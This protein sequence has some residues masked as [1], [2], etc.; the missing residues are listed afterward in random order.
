MQ[1]CGRRSQM[2]VAVAFGIH[3]SQDSI[4]R[5]ACH[6]ADAA[7][8][9]VSV[10]LRDGDQLHKDA[11]HISIRLGTESH[12]IPC[13]PPHHSWEENVNLS[14]SKKDTALVIKLLDKGLIPI[15]LLN[16]WDKD[17]GVHYASVIDF[18]LGSECVWVL[19]NEKGEPAGVITA[20]CHL[21]KHRKFDD[22]S[23]SGSLSTTDNEMDRKRV[24]NP[25]PRHRASNGERSNLRGKEDWEARITVCRVEDLKNGYYY[26]LWGSLVL[27]LK[28][29]DTVVKTEVRKDTAEPEWN[30]QFDVTMCD[31]DELV[32]SLVDTDWGGSQHIVGRGQVSGRAVAKSESLMVPLYEQNS[33]D[34]VG[35][36]LLEVNRKMPQ[37]AHH[38]HPFQQEHQWGMP[39]GT[40]D[41]CS[42]RSREDGLF[43]DRVLDGRRPLDD[44]SLDRHLPFDDRNHDG[45]THFDERRRDGSMPVCE[46]REGGR[47]PVNDSSHDDRMA[48]APRSSVLLDD[49]NAEGLLPFDDDKRNWTFAKVESLL[50]DF[51]EGY[52][53]P[54]Y[55]R[56]EMLL[57]KTEMGMRHLK[58]VEVEV[59]EAK[60][61]VVADIFHTAGT[62]VL[63]DVGSTRMQ[64]TTKSNLKNPRWNERF[65][66][67]DVSGSDVMQIVVMDENS[68][69]DDPLGKAEI[70]IGEF[71][72]QH[73][74]GIW[75]GLQDSRG[76]HAGELLLYCTINPKAASREL[77]ASGGRTNSSL[78]LSRGRGTT[79]PARRSEALPPWQ[80]TPGRSSTS[81][82]LRVVR[83]CDVRAGDEA[84]YQ[85]LCVELRVKDQVWQTHATGDVADPFWNEDFFVDVLPH[86]TLHVA[87]KDQDS[88]HRA[89]PLGEGCVSGK[90]LLAGKPE[91]WVPLKCGAQPA[92]EV[93]LSLSQPPKA[94]TGSPR[95][96]ARPRD[97]SSSE[98]ALIPYNSQRASSSRIAHALR[99]EGASRGLLPRRM[100]E[101]RSPARTPSPSHVQRNMVVR[102][103]KA[104]GLPHM[105]LLGKSDPFVR[106]RVG[107]ATRETTVKYDTLDPEW[108]EEFDFLVW[109]SD[110]MKVSVLD[111]DRPRPHEICVGRISGAD[112]LDKSGQP[113]WVSL[114]D[115][116]GHH[117]RSFTGGSLLLGVD[118]PGLPR[119][120]TRGSALQEVPVCISRAT[121]LPVAGDL[122]ARLTVGRTTH[123][124]VVR[125]TTS[126]PIWNKRASVAIA[127]HDMVTVEVKRK[128]VCTGDTVLCVG[129]VQGRELLRSLG[130]E[131]WLDLTSPLGEPAGAVLLVLRSDLRP[132]RERLTVERPTYRHV[133]GRYG[134]SARRWDDSL[135]PLPTSDGLHIMVTVLHADCEGRTRL[136]H[137]YVALQ[138]GARWQH[139]SVANSGHAAVW[140][141]SFAFRLRDHEALWMELRCLS[142]KRDLV[143]DLVYG[144]VCLGAA[145]VKARL[146]R[147]IEIDLLSPSYPNAATGIMVL[148]IAQC[149]SPVPALGDEFA[150]RQTI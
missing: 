111:N 43:E 128:D 60:D 17:L 75:V 82:P 81:I 139:T 65:R 46:G 16:V 107:T 64:T 68:L 124:T 77:S 42:R 108:N 48:L 20:I 76:Q 122:Y 135:V 94:Y 129:E 44:G 90:Q 115:V 55:D 23:R 126:E 10:F 25:D 113:V 52:R 98:R 51:D 103:I 62:Y 136:L 125:R 110:V 47:V 53:D 45:R 28:V 58:N 148:R 49:A 96:N 150:G 85:G 100:P 105:E 89:R 120:G 144:Q 104:S 54:L 72:R 116:K 131:V 22:G 59:V 32:V 114:S 2:N 5:L 138:V 15:S 24:A 121:A 78:G 146:G 18:G 97:V 143:P 88:S 66:F 21:Q 61:L 29:K 67:I 137:P 37:V 63:L 36:V 92:G 95:A 57:D 86:D 142:Q 6:M 74:K 102:V 101:R 93:C 132:A 83:A 130:G 34:E 56:V 7:D 11:T 13:K 39:D 80:F 127:P 38:R 87:V 41:G 31:T 79:S 71:A 123:E 119:R 141:E 145:E 3:S 133:A 33:E 69:Y 109:P 1:S 4:P 26:R 9:T 112:L 147:K 70:P 73:L 8:G 106:L 99:S 14:W 140:H 50:D 30:Q 91:L 12:E 40:S 84:G 35:K 27:T 117:T 134:D 19:R 149:T 118:L